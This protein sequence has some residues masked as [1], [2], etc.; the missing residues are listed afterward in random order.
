MGTSTPTDKILLKR[1]KFLGFREELLI[2]AYRSYAISHISYS[3]TVLTSA[4]LSAKLEMKAF[5]NRCL[6]I[7]GI[8]TCDAKEK[9]NITAIEKHINTT[10][11]KMLKKM[12]GNLEHP[13]A[14]KLTTTRRTMST[15]LFQKQFHPTT[16]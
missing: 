2:T 3:A 13:I 5:Q 14:V 16:P 6:N 8:N 9:C 11:I 7:I 12:L 10:C 1:L 4:S 15:F